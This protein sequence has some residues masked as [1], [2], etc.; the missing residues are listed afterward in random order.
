MGK[1]IKKAVSGI[2]KVASLGTIKDVGGAV[3]LLTGGLGTQVSDTF[4]GT[5]F[6]GMKADAADAAKA[7][8]AREQAA[9]TLS[10]NLTQD[11]SNPNT[12]EV[13]AGGTATSRRRR[14]GAGSGIS[15]SLGINV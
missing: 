5:D 7:Q 13:V 4:L 2:V 11:L 3:N 10:T 9:A 6:S 1:K 15:S 12:A 8:A 14:R